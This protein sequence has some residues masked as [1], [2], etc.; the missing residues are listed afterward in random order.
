MCLYKSFFVLALRCSAFIQSSDLGGRGKKVGLL[1][2]NQRLSSGASPLCS[3]LRL[4]GWNRPTHQTWL[5]PQLLCE[6]GKHT[7]KHKRCFRGFVTSVSNRYLKMCTYNIFGIC[8]KYLC[9]FLLYMKML[10]SFTVIS[11]NID[12]CK[13]CL[14]LSCF[15]FFFHADLWHVHQPLQQFDHVSLC[16][17]LQAERLW[18]WP[19]AQRASVLGK[20]DGVFWY[21]EHSDLTLCLSQM[22]CE[23]SFPLLCFINCLR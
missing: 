3:K 9:V 23:I 11:R 22:K 19:A 21:W 16:S 2:G 18:R 13:C 5:L 12:S 10:C 14:T 7:Q 15:F 4:A 20:H 1:P 8:K 17:H 6:P